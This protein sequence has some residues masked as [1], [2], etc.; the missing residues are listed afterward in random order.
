MY[1]PS[2]DARVS[3][4]R[5]EY[6]TVDILKQICAR[7][8]LTKTGRK[9]ELIDKLYTNKLMLSRLTVPELSLLCAIEELPSSGTKSVL[10]SQLAD[11]DGLKKYGSKLEQSKWD[12]SDDESEEQGPL[13]RA[14]QS[15]NLGFENT[16][17]QL[18]FS[19]SSVCNLVFHFW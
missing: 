3:E 8:G 5:L 9:A 16:H 14:F 6:F 15:M 17:N 10:I 12:A 11:C 1:S 19:H 18:Q 7:E 2:S 4:E 13:V